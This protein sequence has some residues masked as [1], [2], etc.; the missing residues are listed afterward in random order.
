MTKSGMS[1]VHP[2]E[3]L[4]EELDDL[5]LS[6]NALAKAIDVPANRITAILNAERGITA[7]TALRLG[8][9]FD[10]TAQFWLNLQQTWELRRAE[11]KS[12]PRILE[13]VVPRQAEAL[14]TAARQ[15]VAA[16]DQSVSVLP[17][18]AGRSM[19]K[20]IEQNAALCDQI[21]AAE[22]AISLS[23]SNR[24]LRAL[25]SPLDELRSV[26]AL[27]TTFRRELHHTA[28]WLAEYEKRFRLAN[29]GD[30]SMLVAP[31]ATSIIERLAAITTPWLDVDNPLGSV[32]RILE[33]QK[34]GEVIGNQATFS[35]TVA[36]QVRNW[37]GDWRAL[38]TWPKAIWQDPA[39]RADFYD[40]LGFDADLTDMPAAA[41]R[42]AAEIAHIHSE[43]PSLVESYGSPVPT[44]STATTQ[45]AFSR[46]NEAH[47]WL[48]RFES[49][50]RRFIDTEMTRAFGPEWSRDRLSNGM[51]DQW[52]EKKNA[53]AR[54]RTEHPLIAYADFTDYPRIIT[55]KDNWR[56]VFA[57]HFERP[58]DVRESFCRLLP[59]RRDTMH[60][61][62][63]G[64]DDQLLLYV[65]I[66]RIERAIGNCT[67]A[68]P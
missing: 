19:L 2:G 36:D 64:Q 62:P 7:D 3:V 25:A 13:Y 16:H 68:V 47:D 46:T 50:L 48:Q 4:R 33:L 44:S 59:I 37:L 14:R 65:E 31:P 23:A 20:V 8:R 39:A 32:K 34:I 38:V 56:Q 42:E 61:R 11:T 30:L 52:K 55:R 6:A 21:S 53:A 45:A 49:H 54:T 15:A 26:G 35:G 58:E 57:N 28:Q 17:A 40:D 27:Q 67:T 51:Y 12:G 66:K 22:R 5:G 60:A 29:A 10:T 63:I 24:M 18:A 43:P 41:F 9:Y 1:P